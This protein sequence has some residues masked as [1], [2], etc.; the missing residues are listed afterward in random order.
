MST[1]II[2]PGYSEVIRFD[3]T[4]N[5]YVTDMADLELTS[6]ARSKK[7][8]QEYGSWVKVHAVEDWFSWIKHV[9]D[10]TVFYEGEP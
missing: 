9:S 3:P 2:I 6:I 8:K 7:D 10:R 1:C 5:A 4:K